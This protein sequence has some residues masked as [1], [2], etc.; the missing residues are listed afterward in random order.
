[1][2]KFAVILP[3]AGRSTRFGGME[4]KPFVALDGRPVWLRSAELFWTRP[5]VSTV[6][7]V[8]SADDEELFRPPSGHAGV[9]RRV[10][11]S[12]W[13]SSGSSP[14]RTHWR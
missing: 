7:V 6:L 4:K 1:M 5:D 10:T 3:A 14:W 13:G 8:V 9:R 12:G 11:C 2:P